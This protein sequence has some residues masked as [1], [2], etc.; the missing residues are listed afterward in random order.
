MTL[1]IL[2]QTGVAIDAD[3]LLD[4][5][6]EEKKIDDGSSFAL[7]IEALMRG[8]EIAQY[9]GCHVTITDEGVVDPETGEKL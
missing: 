9:D 6:T 8:L 4:W 2:W 5:L 7:A 1:E 3:A